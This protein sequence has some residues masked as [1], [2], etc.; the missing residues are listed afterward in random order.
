MGIRHSEIVINFLTSFSF[1]LVSGLIDRK[2]EGNV[3]T[4]LLVGPS[5]SD[6]KYLLNLNCSGWGRIPEH[7]VRRSA[8]RGSHGDDY[9][10]NERKPSVLLGMNR[11]GT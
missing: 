3:A 8:K 4:Y 6:Y 2:D 7:R 1:L 9:H 10:E 5:D 11:G